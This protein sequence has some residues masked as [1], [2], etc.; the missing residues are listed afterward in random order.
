MG[1]SAFLLRPLYAT[2]EVIVHLRICSRAKGSSK[3]RGEEKVASGVERA[4]RKK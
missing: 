4:K 1:L 3:E 2:K